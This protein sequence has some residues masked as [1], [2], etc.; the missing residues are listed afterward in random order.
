[1]LTIQ[2]IHTIEGIGNNEMATVSSV[3]KELKVT[4]GTLSVAITKL[5]NKGYILKERSKTD[6]R[7]KNLKLSKKGQAVYDVHEQFHVKFVNTI[8]KNVNSGDMEILLNCLEKLNLFF[9]N[10]CN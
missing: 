3:A 9:N 7:I 5:I 6:K 8:T 1:M 10:D 2:D 4:N